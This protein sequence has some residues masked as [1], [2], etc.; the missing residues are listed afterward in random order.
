MKSIIK[1]VIKNNIKNVIFLGDFFYNRNS[2]NIQSLY[3][4]YNYLKKICEYTKV[5]MILGNHD[6]FLKNSKKYHSVKPFNEIKNLFVISETETININGGRLT[7]CPWG[8]DIKG[9]NECDCLLGHFNMNG[10]ELC[11]SI[12]NNGV[13]GMNDLTKIAPLVFSGHFHIRKEY[14]TKD[15]KVITVGNPLQQTWGDY[16]NKKGFYIL[17]PHNNNYKFIEN[18]LT[19]IYHKFLWSEVKTGIDKYIKDIK[20]NYIKLVIDEEYK[21]QDILDLQKEIKTYNPLSC[22][23]EYVFSINENLLKSV[24]ISQKDVKV[25]KSD[26]MYEFIDKLS[27]ETDQKINWDNVRDKLKQYYELVG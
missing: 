1:Y 10:S 24:E 27:K 5:Y 3:I 4:V 21:F 2:V 23:I 11:G 8:T 18:T 25:N 17:T 6:M 20:N 22:N 14:N 16:N 19:P 15:G 12:Y 7:L 26:Y 13:Y 9:V